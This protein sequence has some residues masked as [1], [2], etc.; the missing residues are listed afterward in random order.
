M[1]ASTR[2]AARAGQ[3]SVRWF[4]ATRPGAALL[5]IVLHRIDKLTFR[6]SHG[7]RTATP[8]LAGLPVIMLTTI[9]ARSGQPHTVPV[10][11]FPVDG[12]LAVAAG[13]FG[14]TRDP[15]WCLNLRRE[16]HATVVV[17]A[18]VR[19]VIADELTGAARDAVWQRCLAIYPG[20]TTY[21]ARA[22][23]RTIAIF[24]LRPESSRN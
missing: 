15:A 17:D 3:R 16:A 8:V 11:G 5:A 19:H 18:E 12:N 4:A 14:R 24:L 2:A 23:N 9:G 22:G 13:N 21:A 1:R 7:R 6:L 10:L 20:G